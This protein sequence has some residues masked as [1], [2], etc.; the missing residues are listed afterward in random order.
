MLREH[1]LVALILS[2]H[3]SFSSSKGKLAPPASFTRPHA[4]R[5]PFSMAMIACPSL[6]ARLLAQREG[7]VALAPAALI[8]TMAARAAISSV[9]VRRKR[10]PLLDGVKRAQRTG[11]ITPHHGADVAPQMADPVR[12]RLKG[13]GGRPSS[14]LGR[15]S[16]T[17]YFFRK[18]GARVHTAFSHWRY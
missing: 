14:F 3:D 16:G 13:W 1:Q 6:V 4:R 17:P 7:D 11:G 8:A 9:D 18:Y 15:P 12:C 2:L 5:P 10:P